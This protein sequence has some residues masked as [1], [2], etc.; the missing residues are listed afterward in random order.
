MAGHKNLIFNV[1]VFCAHKYSFVRY[2]RNT[3]LFREEKNT[4]FITHHSL[5]GKKRKQQ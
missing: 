3:S 2:I 4:V 5:E 1:F